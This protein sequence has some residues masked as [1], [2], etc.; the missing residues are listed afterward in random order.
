MISGV[1]W[2]N[3]TKIKL[4]NN[5]LNV[6]G[7]FTFWRTTN[8]AAARKKKKKKIFNS[9]SKSRKIIMIIIGEEIDT[10]FPFSL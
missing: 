9:D 7:I 3:Y 4:K 5:Y 6:K 8:A 2:K 1:E 10:V